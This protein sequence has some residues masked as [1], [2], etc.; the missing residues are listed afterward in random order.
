MSK[1]KKI[2]KVK[3]ELR[4]YKNRAHIVRSRQPLKAMP[5]TGEKKKK[6]KKEE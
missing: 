4:E 6:S 2:Q 5:N 3:N 1:S